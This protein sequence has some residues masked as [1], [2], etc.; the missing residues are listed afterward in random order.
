[1]TLSKEDAI[2]ALN[3]WGHH[4]QNGSVTNVLACYS[5]SATLWPTLSNT[6]RSSQDALRDYFDMFLPKVVGP[7]D[8]TQVHVTP[9]GDHHCV[10]SGCYI[11]DLTTGPTSARFTYVLAA[12]PDG[13]LFIEH[14]H[15]SLMPE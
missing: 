2:Q 11:F 8:W 12:Q 10:C 9:L 5:Q 15:S 3:N 14:H 4:V 6:H 13:T 1:M 7:V